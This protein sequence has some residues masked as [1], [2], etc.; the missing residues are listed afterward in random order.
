MDKELLHIKTALQHCQFPNWALNQWEHRFKHPN[1]VSNT[2]SNNSNPNNH[3]DSN[4]KYRTTILVPY[5][6]NTADKFKRLCKGWNIQV[7][8]KGTNTLRTTLVNPKDKEH[9]TK[10]TVVI[11]QYQC[12]HIQCSSSYIGESG[13]SLGE[14]VKEHLKPPSPIHLHSTTRGHPMDPNQFNIMHKDVHS[15]SRTIKEA[16]FICVQDSP[17]LQHRQILTATHMGPATTVI[18]SV[19]TKT[20]ITTNYHC[21]HLPPY[22][23]PLTPH[24]LLSC[25]PLRWG[26]SYFSLILSTMVSTCVHLPTHPLSLSTCRSTAVPPW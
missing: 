5:I 26:A 8:F 9:K 10:Q 3:K 19:P 17:Q 11:F 22:W 15:Q 25:C 20:N 14:R 16:M 7:Q 4:N 23:Y 13:R 24:P 2:S 1:Q 6:P 18:S 12:P 21:Q